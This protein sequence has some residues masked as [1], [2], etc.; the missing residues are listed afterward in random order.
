MSTFGER[1]EK[2]ARVEE[3]A[4]DSAAAAPKP[5]QAA[6]AG[7]AAAIDIYV[8]PDV[9]LSGVF[10]AIGLRASWPLRAV[11]RRWRHVVQDMEWTSLEV[12]ATEA[13]SIASG[14]HGQARMRAAAGRTRNGEQ[15]DMYLALAAL[16]DQRVRKLRLSAGASV[17]LRPKL[18]FFGGVKAAI[19]RESHRRTV[20]AACSVLE[21]INGSHSGSAQPREVIVELRGADVLRRSDAD[22][23]KAYVLGVLSALQPSEGAVS[24]LKSLSI[25]CTWDAGARDR[26]RPDDR[27]R[28]AAPDEMRTALAP[29]GKLESLDLFSRN[30]FGIGADAAAAIVAACP[31]LKSLCITPDFDSSS[32]LAVLT[33]LAPLAHLEQL[34]F[35]LPSA[36]SSYGVGDSL[37]ALADG[38]AGKSLKSIAL[39]DEVG[40]YNE[41]EFPRRIPTRCCRHLLPGDAG[42]LA[43]SRMPRLES[44]PPLSIDPNEVEP[45]ALLALGH[46]AS[47]READVSIFQGTKPSRA[48]AALRAL[49]ETISGLPHL[50]RVRLTVNMFGH[51]TSP[52]TVVHLLESPGARRTLASLHLCLLRPLTEAEAEAILALSALERLE[53]DLQR[54]PTLRDAQITLHSPLNGRSAL[55]GT[56][57]PA[58]LRPLEILR[59]LH[60]KVELQVKLSLSPAS[61]RDA[62]VEAVRRLYAERSRWRTSVY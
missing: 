60:P 28:F 39:F 24:A 25:G 17:A 19:V 49:A 45:A 12:A 15:A 10:K 53:L 58:P 3:P 55:H 30:S 43:L 11:C 47:L 1:A 21:V 18:A 6:A 41:G 40:L 61:E 31:L 46:A 26:S 37:V 33:A 48:A 5:S 2:R 36:M 8:L 38:P 16:L 27:L 50:E 22:F 42:L 34:V 56:R 29:F 14:A 32:F 7:A 35:S 62:A 51:P 13:S 23:L 44:V 9:V 20:A 4:P 54:M 52:D 59:R 57:I